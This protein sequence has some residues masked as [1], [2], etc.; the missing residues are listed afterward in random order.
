MQRLDAQTVS[1]NFFRVLGVAPMLGRDFR[2]EDEKP[3]K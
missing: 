2:W 3:G 1:S